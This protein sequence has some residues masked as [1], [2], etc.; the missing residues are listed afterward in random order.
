MRPFKLT[1]LLAPIAVCALNACAMSEVYRKCGFS[2]CPGD[3]KISSDVESALEKHL[4]IET[5]SIQ[6]QTLD[7][8]VYL[9]GLVATDLERSIIET[10]ASNTP[11]VTHV[12]DSIGIRANFR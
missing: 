8:V 9:Y 5:S 1:W 4:D 11:G 7:G 6:V 10:L 3:K 12:V 2:G